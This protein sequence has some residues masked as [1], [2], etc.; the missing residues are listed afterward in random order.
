V[1]LPEPTSPITATLRPPAR[2]P[3][4]RG[5]RARTWTGRAVTLRATS[6]GVPHVET[7]G[8]RRTRVSEMRDDRAAAPPAPLRRV[9]ARRVPEL[10]ESPGGAS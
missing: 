4:R 7:S 8:T 5:A 9:P 10:S 6:S 3:A 1:T 2:R